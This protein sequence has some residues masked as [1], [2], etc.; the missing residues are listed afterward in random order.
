MDSNWHV[1]NTYRFRKSTDPSTSQAYRFWSVVSYDKTHRVKA[2]KDFEG[3]PPNNLILEFDY[4][5]ERIPV[6]YIDNEFKTTAT[7]S[8][9]VTPTQVSYVPTENV[10]T[11][12]NTRI[13]SQA[14]FQDPNAFQLNT[15][16]SRFGLPRALAKTIL[17]MFAL[18]CLPYPIFK[19]D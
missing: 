13:D 4:K 16:A 11:V 8:S 17:S 1:V 12:S 2:T 7:G 18:N 3:L 10:D 15:M 5:L 9:I 6:L 19:L 14:T